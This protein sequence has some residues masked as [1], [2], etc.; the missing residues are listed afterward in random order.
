MM[1]PY[2]TLLRPS[3]QRNK[4]SDASDCGPTLVAQRN[5]PAVQHNQIAK[6]MS[7]PSLSNFVPSVLFPQ[8]IVINRA[9]LCYDDP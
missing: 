4:L 2:R 9:S 5:F 6:F 7:L 3:V 8:I 1:G